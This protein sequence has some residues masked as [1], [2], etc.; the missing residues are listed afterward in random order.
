MAPQNSGQEITGSV[1]GA[2]LDP[3]GAVFVSAKVRSPTKIR[4]K[5]RSRKYRPRERIIPAA[6]AGTVHVRITEQ[7]FKTVEQTVDREPVGVITSANITLELGSEA[8]I[9]GGEL[10]DS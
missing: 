10:G 3:K 4:D 9:T 5:S 1:Q 2:I 8:V 6:A 7:G